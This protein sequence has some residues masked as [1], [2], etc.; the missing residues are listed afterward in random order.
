MLFLHGFCVFWIKSVLLLPNSRRKNMS[1]DKRK[2]KFREMR[3]LT[4]LEL[5]VVIAVIGIMGSISVPFFSRYNDQ[6]SVNAAMTDILN[7]IMEAKLRALYGNNHAVHFGSDGTVTLLSNAGNDGKWGTGDDVVVKSFRIGEVGR[8]LR[9]GYGS[10]GPIPKLADH[11]DGITFNDHVAICNNDMTGT[12]GTVYVIS[13]SG[14]AMA[15]VLNSTDSGYA[16]W[17]WVGTKWIKK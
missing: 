6:C 14:N 4:I 9:F 7:M 8:G 13:P 1:Y 2:L 15:L 10:F 11:Q 17:K 3:G 12:A 5:M 16:V